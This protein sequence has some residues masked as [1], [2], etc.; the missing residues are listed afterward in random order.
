M[1]RNPFEE[2]AFA[3]QAGEVGELGTERRNAVP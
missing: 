3:D 1:R 2:Y